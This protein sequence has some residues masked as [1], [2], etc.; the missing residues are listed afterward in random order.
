MA[1]LGNVRRQLARLISPNSNIYNNA[2]YG[3]LG[4]GFTEYDR[5]A[6]TYINEGYT[7][8]PDVYSVI[9]QQSIKHA[10]IP[11]L[12]KIVKDKKAKRQL[13]LLQFQT[14]GNY[15]PHQYIKKLKLEKDAYEDEYLEWPL[16]KPNPVQTWA[17][18]SQLE[19]TFLKSTGNCFYYAPSPENGMNAG[20]PALLY[21]LPAH[22][23]QI[24][25]RQGVG[26][27]DLLSTDSPIAEYMLVEGNQYIT[28]PVEDVF[29]VKY[30]NPLYDESGSQLYGLSPL[31]A[32]LRNIQS[33]NEAISNNIKALKN[34][35]AFG[36]IHGKSSVLT[37]GQAKELKE[38]L[39]EMD[40]STER[41]SKIAGV[42]AEIG[43]TRLSLTTNELK[44]FD[45]LKNDQ[46]TICNVLGWSDLLLNNDAR[47]DYGGTISQIEKQVIRNNI[48]PDNDLFNECWQENFIKRFKGYE[49]AVVESYYDD[50][51]E[52]QDDMATLM[53]WVEKAINIGLISRNEAREVI[54]LSRSEDT[55]MDIVTVRDDVIPLEEALL[56]NFN[57]TQGES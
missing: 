42:S 49:N 9:Q 56:D 29:H 3:F 51:P 5:N 12:V 15:T 19:K 13:D 30:A 18:I 46:K 36:F 50:L 39:N 11:R 2:F 1:I 40:S 52:M 25:L 43:F 10:S 47:G 4:A 35:G 54:K 17:E 28:F 33:S 45:Y 22:Q 31:R 34:G 7:Y 16:P 57:M 48:M 21:V 53:E 26:K 41:L 14:K 32:A 27:M 6:D 44:P 20:Q 55:N 37:P 24:V 23:M 38:R 8:N